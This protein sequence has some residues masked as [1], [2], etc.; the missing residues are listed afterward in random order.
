MRTLPEIVREIEDRSRR[1]EEMHPQ[2]SQ[3]ERDSLA[4]PKFSIAELRLL[5]ESV[6]PTGEMAVEVIREIQGVNDALE[7][8][9]D[10]LERVVGLATESELWKSVWR[11][12]D[13]TVRT[14]SCLL[15]IEHEA[16]CSFV[17]DMDFGRNPSTGTFEGEEFT[18]DSIESFVKYAERC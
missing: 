6:P 9:F 17:H 12:F 4:G 2:L 5:V 8:M 16:L 3:L 14:A 1:I 18:V 10:D 13:L 11:G 15:G 7:T